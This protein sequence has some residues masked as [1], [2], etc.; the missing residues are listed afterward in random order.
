MRELVQKNE[1]DVRLDEEG[2]PR[3]GF[4]CGGH[5]QERRKHEESTP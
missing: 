4:R 1:L 5:P 3:S 2:F